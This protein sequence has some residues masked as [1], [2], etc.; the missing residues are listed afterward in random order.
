MHSE[1]EK[2]AVA[3]HLHVLMRRKMGR[4][5]DVEWLVRNADYA[6]EIIRLACQQAEHPEVADWGARLR[7]MLFPK[8]PPAPSP[9]SAS[10]SAGA[11]PV[12]TRYVG[13]LR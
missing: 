2:M 12:A 4:V 7:T 11:A 9:K 3:A 5:T 1:S 6:Q 13:G 8:P 10:A